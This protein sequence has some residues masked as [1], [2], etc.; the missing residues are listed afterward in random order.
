MPYQGPK[1]Q[2]ESAVHFYDKVGIIVI[3]KSNFKADSK[4]LI[5]RYVLRKKLFSRLRRKLELRLYCIDLLG[6]E[7]KAAIMLYK[8][9]K[10]WP[11]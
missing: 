4:S 6:G 7:V 9:M 11:C 2:C 10:Q 5:Q 8:T 1:E 3:G